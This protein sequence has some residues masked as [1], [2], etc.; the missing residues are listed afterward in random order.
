M[1]RIIALLLVFLALTFLAWV[2][3][4]G[5]PP[6]DTKVDELI[7][8]GWDE[9][10]IVRLK[11]GTDGEWKKIWSWKASERKELPDS[12]KSRLGTTDE[13]KLVEGGK[14]VLV[15]SSG[16]AVVLIEKET[17]RVSFYALAANAHSADILP[18]GRLAVAASHEPDGS[19]DRLI[20]FD[21]SVPGKEICSAALPWGHGAVWDEKRQVL[22]ALGDQ[23][24]RVFRI[25]N[26]ESGKP[27]LERLEVIELPESGGHDLYP[28]PGST[29]LSVT[30]GGHCWL[31]ER[32]RKIFKL[33]PYLADSANVKSISVNQS[34]GQLAWIGAEGDNWW[35]QRVHLLNPAQNLLFPGMHLYKARWN[36]PAE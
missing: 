11:P 28:V 34:T 32:D 23:D 33:H 27:F 22:W 9:V 13:C 2:F 29:W 16:G 12:V 20:V 18:G 3:P 19:G 26:R 15:T 7:L 31:F 36:M 30:T 5:E 35:A 6:G 8:C 14:S 1:K 17:G 4:A 10:F 21:L 24:I 25:E